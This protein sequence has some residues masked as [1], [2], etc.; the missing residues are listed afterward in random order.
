MPEQIL[1]PG[2][3]N[4]K[5]AFVTG[6]SGNIGTAITRRLLEE[7]ASVVLTGRNTTK[8]EEAR[9]RLL[10]EVG[11]GDD[12][13]LGLA[14]DGADPDST[15]AAVAAA[16]ARFGRIDV[17]VN[18]AGSA[19]PRQKL[20]NVPV[21]REE[22]DALRAAGSTDTET[23]GDAARN[24]LGVTW[25]V[26]RAAAPALRA[27]ASVI[28]ISTI[29]SRTAYFGRTA[30]VVPKATLNA[31]SRRF[32]I[33]LG[34]RG[35]RVNTLYPGPIESERIRTVFAAMDKLREEDSGTTAAEFFGLMSLARARDGRPPERT[36]PTVLDVAN[37][38][39]FLGSDESAAISGHDLEVT[40]GMAVRK[41][42][43]STWLSRPSQRTVDGTGR[44]ALLAGGEQVED[45][46][47]L[48]R[49]VAA[50]GASVLL[51]LER[52]EDVR[53]AAASLGR[54]GDARITAVLLDRTRPQTLARALEAA[55]SRIDGVIILPAMPPGRLG[56]A[57]SAVTDADLDAFV[58]RE[59]VGAIAISRE[60]AR[61]WQTARGT[62]R[63]PRIVFVSNA[64]DGA[65]NL[66]ADALRAGQEEL[67]RV[68]RQ[69]SEARIKSNPRHRREWSNQIIRYTNQEP[70]GLAFAGG[71]VT[72]LLFTPRHIREVNLYLPASI[73]DATG[74][75]R[76]SLGWMDNLKGLHLGK[77]ALVT[78][79]SGGIG[80][81]IGRLL[82]CAGARVML[83]AR[84]EAQ[85]AE[86]RNQ[87]VAE[88]E[89]CGYTGAAARVQTLAGVDVAD[90]AAAERALDVT[91]QTFGRIDY[92]VNCAGV[93]GA[94]EMV[95]DMA[96]DDWRR[97]LDANLVSNYA[98]IQKVV[99][100]MKAQGS[101]YVVNV[102]SYFGG[103]KYVATAY[104]NRADYAVS[105]AGQRALAENLARLL[106]PEIQ[107]NAIAPGP[108]AGDRLQGQ[109]G[110]PGLYERRAKL[111]LENKRLNRLHAALVT[112]VRAGAQAG[113]L[114]D[115][116]A[117]NDVGALERMPEPLA[118]LVAPLT[119]E[120]R[121]GG[122]CGHFLLTRVLA[123]KLV[124]RL[125]NGGYLSASES[126]SFGAS[127]VAALPEPPAPFFSAGS[128]D[129]AAAKI[130]DDVLSLLHLQ[131]MP[132]ETDVALA[133]VFYLADRAVSGETFLPSGGL[134]L[135][136]SNTERELF[137]SVKKA[138]LEMLKDQTVWL[139][140]EHLVPHLTHAA[141]VLAEQGRV[142]R[143][144][145]LLH[146]AEAADAFRARLPPAVAA[147]SD[148][149]VVGD[150]LEEGMDE[151]QRLH[152]FPRTIV[153][154]PFGPLPSRI[155]DPAESSQPLDTA[156]FR[157]LIE[158][159]VTHHFRVARRAALFDHVQLILV[160]PDV[161]TGSSVE[162]F[163][164]ANF[165]KTTL[166]A[167]TG[168]VAVECERLVH[169]A[170][171]NQVNLTRR[172]RSEEPRNDAETQ[173]EIER[174]GRAVLL[175]GAPLPSLEDSRYR[176]RIYRGMAITV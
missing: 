147:K 73:V 44:T 133:T 91:L 28:N 108:V 136:R 120:G 170:I 102:S 79:G 123:V 48:A 112:A 58:D 8:L 158:T 99:P 26:T 50:T 40:H 159:N 146:T 107:I 88:L 84:G 81:Q 125:A 15:R 135:E 72:R 162:A 87:I 17:L 171:V 134:S 93:A 166:H 139:I 145:F 11:A 89:D 4:Q 127:W 142:G 175:A 64:D 126:A 46:I 115:L 95:V 113:A 168:T 76:A 33:E 71:Q 77:V 165:I 129:V 155:F 128:I 47:T 121:E 80:A 157:A 86:R 38:V 20:E 21:T 176:S 19:G 10:A 78:G 56:G 51:G 96:L 70:E 106:G 122:S 161:P 148:L 143:I 124:N 83:V 52:D 138:R 24:L 101:G 65:G 57:L 132:T 36:F 85:L 61:Y 163:A 74:A 63:G 94:E 140:G 30:Y 22:L 109:G 45:A 55:P 169:D 32:A 172:V 34:E 35:I 160:S 154:T 105:K 174:F 130:R 7:G 12:R 66:Y 141:T 103:E 2:R 27:G 54:G 53:A 42:S 150:R 60:L 151:A 116:L 18:N 114:L 110:K 164:L 75:R 167:L 104:P 31:V 119:A 156:G 149:L 118:A 9:A 92:L 62:G 13:A 98:L 69:E 111:I 41:E 37:V 5:V 23:A 25:N 6:A 82:A 173:E 3:M 14:M 90:L 144:V 1:R 131:R 152:G 153:S 68:W 29:F 97:T 117:T 137:G 16:I 49:I 67:C 59:L 43:R 100:H 39:L